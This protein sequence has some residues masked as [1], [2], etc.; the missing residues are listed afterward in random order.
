MFTSG[1]RFTSAGTDR[2]GRPAL[3]GSTKG[4]RA[5]RRSSVLS[6]V[7]ALL[8][9]ALVQAAPADVVISQVYGGGGN[10][11]AFYKNDFVEL[12]NR[13]TLPVSLAGMSIQYTSASGTGN[14]GANSGQITPLPSVTLLPGQYFLVQEAAGSGGTSALPTPDAT[15]SSPINMS[16]TG[17][18]VALVNSTTGLGCNGGSTP[19]SPAQLALIVD[20]VGW[21]GANFYEGSGPAPGTS[22]TTAV[23]RANGGCTDTDDNA[24]D[25]TV[26]APTPRNTASPIHDC[27]APTG[28]GLA[29]P[30][31]ASPGD[32]TLL[33]VTVTPG[34][35]PT[36]TGL[37]VTA[38][39]SAIGGAAVQTFYDDG[40]N[41]DAA[42]GDDVFSY[43]A[44]VAGGTPV[45]LKTLAATITDDQARTGYATITLNVVPE[46]TAIH[47]IQG[48]G[49]ASPLAGQYVS[50]TGI[51]TGVKYNG[52]FIQTP[53][54]LADNDP[55]TSEG[56]FVFTSS[57]PS[58]AVAVGDSLLVAGTVQEYVPSSDPY[59]PPMTEIAGSP[60]FAV[61][62][63]GNPLP[64][65]VT[66][67]KPDTTPD[68]G[69]EQLERFEGMRVHVRMLNVVAP[70]DGSLDEK[71]A[72]STSD[73]VF[74]GVLPGIA[75]PFVE[76]GILEP[77]ALPPDAPCCVPRFD[78]D[79]EK[80][81]VDSDALVGATPIEVTAGATV[82]G[83]TGPLDYAFR[84]Y[85]IDNDPDAGSAVRGNESAE[86]VPE[87][88]PAE[89]TV[90]TANLQ[91]FYDT[92][93]DPTTSDVVLTP[94]AFA[95][96]LNKVSLAIRKVMKFPDVLGVE[97]VEN[98]T[99]LQA[100]ADKVNADAAAAG[101]PD[102][103]YAAYLDEGND[104]GGIDVGFLVKTPKVEVVTVEQKGKDAEY[105]DPVSKTDAMLNDRPPLVLHAL[106]H[107]P[108]GAPFPVTVIVNHLRSLSD[109]NADPGDGPRVRAK[110]AA[111][112]VFLANLI[113]GYQEAGEAVI[114]VGDYNA[115]QFSDGYVDVIGTIEGTPAPSDQVIL[116]T[117]AGLVDPP[118]VDLV[119]LTA[120]R[121]RYS[122]VFDGNAEELDHI[123]VTRD[124]LARVTG[125]AYARDNADFPESYRNDPT[126][127]ERYSD[128]DVPV[129][130]VQ[131]P[132]AI[133]GASAS[134]S[135][136][137]P[138]NRRMVQVTVDYE[139][140]N[141]CGDDP[142]LSW[143]GVASNEPPHGPGNNLVSPD[144]VVLG[145]HRVLL[146]A[147]RDGGGSGRVYTITITAR[148]AKG[149][150]TTQNVTVT[151]PLTQ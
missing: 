67:K 22:N 63:S 61:L 1:V 100:I 43:R 68:G 8:L 135:V 144:W 29:T 27:T 21:D 31:L 90:A 96:R 41:G 82:T 36:S 58:S 139:L 47:D 106:I 116:P 4:E 137:W 120:P 7:A 53:D 91:R 127:P 136:L 9:A 19:C 24:A 119:N 54:A 118:L 14:F 15:D 44:T 3:A 74:Y 85:T 70:T 6:A 109:I 26:G 145:P 25:F 83:L 148:D 104:V 28:F 140:Q 66:L 115:T 57:N 121:R 117:P 13:S 5:M 33:T 73:G 149:N 18:K 37:A 98:L 112:A 126:R 10:S 95:D 69:P 134:P 51:V 11:G 99:T 77:G 143:L 39:L 141:A 35:T 59:S 105:Y 34:V 76:P 45:G 122:Y 80:L 125:Y 75:R 129:V 88:C 97:E 111:Q 94:E 12:F 103:A 86:P 38:D 71:D 56:I 64:F 30:S 48:P 93:N 102:P 150:T 65:P 124:L 49:T 16:G 46:P 50:T 132:T 147:D 92:V 151:V 72:V 23:L 62:S 32:A 133:S 128:H 87:A 107:G 130:Y 101:Q 110:R 60:A 146:R 138:P 40:S 123:L 55:D 142:V 84:T 78:G 2:R 89:L 108:A 113:Q 131:L 42:A 79:P 20:L 114:S 81:R 52:F 17:G